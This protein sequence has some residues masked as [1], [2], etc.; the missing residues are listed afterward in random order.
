MLRYPL[1]FDI[2]GLIAGNGFV[3]S[4]SL[5]G[6]ALV[7]EE[8]TGGAVWIFGVNPGG[9][10]ADAPTRGE[11]FQAFKESCFSVVLDLAELSGTFEEFKTA[12][13]RFFHETNEPTEREWKDAVTEVREGQL[14]VEGLEKGSA[15]REP[16]VAVELVAAPAVTAA[17]DNVTA[18][19]IPSPAANQQPDE[20]ALAA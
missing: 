18:P 9:A 12:V 1:V 7:E 11:A 4:V 5:H 3:A 16:L 14:A 10:A 15:D 17:N 6:R 8:E 20:Q 2:G 13:D 19:V